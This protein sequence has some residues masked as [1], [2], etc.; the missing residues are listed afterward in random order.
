MNESVK[1]FEDL[2]AW[3]RGRQVRLFAFHLSKNLPAE[4]KFRLK[5]QLLRSARSVTANIAEGYGR[6]HYKENLQYCRQARGSLCETLDHMIAGCDE[7]LINEE[8][9]TEFRGIYKDALR[10]L[11]GYIKYLES[12]SP[13]T[14][15]KTGK[16]GEPAPSYG[17]S[18]YT[19]PVEFYE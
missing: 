18:E 1:S 15:K 12:V 13:G 19:I 17:T 7:G 16:V 4:E 6:Y 14:K 8:T 9:L 11:N 10:T 3:Q 5:D 2:R